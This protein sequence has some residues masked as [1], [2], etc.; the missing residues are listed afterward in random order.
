MKRFLLNPL[1]CVL[2]SILFIG[3]AGPVAQKTTSP[4]VF[5]A[6]QF[7]GS[8][9]VQEADNLLIILDASSSMAE[10]FQGQAKIRLAKAAVGHINQT[11][12]NSSLTAG[13]RTF[14][15]H[16]EFT[17][18]DTT[19][20]YG[21]TEYSRA[22]LDKALKPIKPAGTSPMALA[23]E[24]AGQD[25][26][27]SEGNI[28]LII[29]SDGKIKKGDPISA[30]E[31]IKGQFG[32]RLCI[33]TVLIGDDPEGTTLIEKIGEVG[34]CEIAMEEE[35]PLAV[36]T[37]TP[38]PKPR[39]RSR[40]AHRPTPTPTPTPTTAPTQRELGII[41]FDFG[42]W[43][44]K[45]MYNAILDN[46]ARNMKD[47][48]DLRVK[49]NGHT[50]SI[51]SAEYNQELSEKRARAAMEYLTEQKD[52]RE[53]RLIPEGFSFTNPIADNR[54]SDGR[55]KNRRCEFYSVK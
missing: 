19:L 13:L 42:N 38:T 53:W 14:G 3:C 27:S 41:H 4:P 55:A 54:T 23:I 51:G 10:R 34:K 15:Q 43:D 9:Y 12:Q 37:Y 28:A 45:P 7:E 2:L 16:L 50:D 17:G 1:F 39:P 32:E 46:I 26:E 18:K 47:D 8:E 29:V 11:I 40:P 35:T 30:A 49:I 31:K 36:P 6:S 20:I 52:V 21:L 5:K 44:I 24:A 33:A 22:G 25:L 48:P